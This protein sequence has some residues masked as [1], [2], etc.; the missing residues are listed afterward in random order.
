MSGAKDDT[1]NGFDAQR[2]C[3]LQMRPWSLILTNR[4]S[5]RL[6]FF[7]VPSHWHQDNVADKTKEENEKSV[8]LAK[9]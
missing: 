1:H 6:A 7:G 2:K 8:K 5:L 3:R 4:G 9:P